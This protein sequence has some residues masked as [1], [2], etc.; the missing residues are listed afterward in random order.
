[1]RSFQTTEEFAA[2]HLHGKRPSPPQSGGE[3]E[4]APGAA[5]TRQW[6]EAEPPVVQAGRVYEI[7]IRGFL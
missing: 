5:Q 7:H 2:L 4:T 3:D 1:V 6:F